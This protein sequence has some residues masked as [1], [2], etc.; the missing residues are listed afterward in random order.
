[1][2]PQTAQPGR[3]CNL[4][5]LGAGTSESCVVGENNM[6]APVTDQTAV[7]DS[8]HGLEFPFHDAIGTAWLFLAHAE[9]NRSLTGRR[10]REMFVIERIATHEG[11]ARGSG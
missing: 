10:R 3:K 4:D 5:A 9:L 11:S 2:G 6:A 8:G 1:M 7:G